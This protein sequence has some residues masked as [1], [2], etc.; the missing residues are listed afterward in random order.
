M[1]TLFT[2]GYVYFEDKVEKFELVVKDNII[3]FIGKKYQGNADK[4]ID[5]NGKLVM[6]GFINMHAHS[7]M[8]IMRG[9]KDDCEL[10]TWLYDYIF[11]VEEKMTDED[12]YYGTLLSIM[13]YVRGGTTCC[14]DMYAAFLEPRFK[15]FNDSGFRANL[16]LDSHFFNNKLPSS[17]IIDYN[18][19]LHS[20]YTTDEK[21]ISDAV[22]TA[23]KYN[24]PISVH[25]C[26]TLTE[27]G[28]C[29]AKHN[30]TPIEYLNEFGV[31]NC[32]VICA[33]CVHLHDN[34]F[35]ILAG[36]NVSVATNP[37]SNLKLASGIAQL[38][39]MNN[40]GV[41][42]TIG[43]DSSASNNVLDMAKEVTT[44][45]LLQKGVLNLPT[46]IDNKTALSFATKNAAKALGKENILGELKEGYLAD[47][48]IL[49]INEP[50]YF[51][52][53]N[54]SD[55]LI[56]SIN[57]K[58]VYLTMINGKIVYENGEYFLAETKEKIYSKLLE[59]KERLLKF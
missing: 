20:V 1:R 35:E 40:K 13:E 11:K 55:N 39:A 8:S 24:I 58:D 6:P 48:F 27:V 47:L 26:E 10:E 5:L 19:H 21:I 7:P 36:E 54:L 17:D 29:T 15:A 56:Y 16:S 52:Q 44:C 25:T 18:V 32:K 28:N 59:I 12:V 2:N 3:E 23:K 33:H 46:A 4:I 57:S 38:Y 34:D 31:F 53:N 9:I 42:I 14:L 41:N 37:I 51:P 22:L 49:D 50:N 30:M 43:T 45:S